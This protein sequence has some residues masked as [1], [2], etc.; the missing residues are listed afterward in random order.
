MFFSSSQGHDYSVLIGF[1][2]LDNEALLPMKLKL[3]L[4]FEEKKLMKL[5]FDNELFIESR[6][7]CRLF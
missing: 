1:K 3:K 4:Y 6:G 5:Y 2:L 7:Q